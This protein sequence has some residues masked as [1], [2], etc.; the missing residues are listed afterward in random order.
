MNCCKA[1][2][3][4]QRSQWW[5]LLGSLISLAR[6][7]ASESQ[8]SVE[9]RCWKPNSCN[10]TRKVSSSLIF[11][12]ASEKQ[13]AP[14]IQRACSLTLTCT[15]NYEWGSIAR[16]NHGMKQD[17][18]NVFS[19]DLHHCVFQ[20]MTPHKLWYAAMGSHSHNPIRHTLIVSQDQVRIVSGAWSCT[21]EGN[22][23]DCP[24]DIWAR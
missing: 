7:A 18:G 4:I 16:S 19:C 15:W 11:L 6:K 13:Y 12:L 10:S 2:G 22:L 20:W 21:T 14:N 8:R 17:L 23:S 1:R 24:S 3:K 9:T 5:N